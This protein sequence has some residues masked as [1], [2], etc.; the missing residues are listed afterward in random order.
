MSEQK[1]TPLVQGDLQSQANRTLIES[2]MHNLQDGRGCGC[3]ECLRRV[4]N[5]RRWLRSGWISDEDNILGKERTGHDKSYF[6]R[7]YP[8]EN[9]GL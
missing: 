2:Q 6:D 5:I 9:T 3:P 4:S 7:F 1:L 8:G